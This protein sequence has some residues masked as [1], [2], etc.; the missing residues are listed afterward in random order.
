MD[1]TN[2]YHLTGVYEYLL[3]NH[4]YQYE[5]SDDPSA[6]AKGLQ[7][8]KAINF[9]ASLIDKRMELWN[10]YCPEGMKIK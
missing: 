8:K 1:M 6:Y 10:T 3:N 7:E 2:S 9:I 5:Y 4:D